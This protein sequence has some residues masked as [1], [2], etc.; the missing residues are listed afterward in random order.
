MRTRSTLA[1]RVG[2]WLPVAQ[3]MPEAAPPRS[4]HGPL[5][6]AWPQSLYHQPAPERSRLQ[7]VKGWVP[8][9][10]GEQWSRSRSSVLK[11]QPSWS[12]VRPKPRNASPA[13]RGG[14]GGGPAAPPARAPVVEAALAAS[15]SETAGQ[16]LG[17]RQPRPEH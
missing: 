4:G 1:R 8:S 17:E 11:P 15:A 7:L 2:R 9:V 16:T 10:Q 12:S 14:V 6:S 3:R 5:R 13:Q